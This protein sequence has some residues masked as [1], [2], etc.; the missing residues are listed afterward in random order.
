MLVEKKIIG[1]IPRCYA[2]TPL[3][4]QGGEHLLVASE[5]KERCVLYGLDG[6]EEEVIWTEPGGVMTMLQVPETDGIFLSTQFFYSPNDAEHGKIVVVFP[7]DGRWLTRTLVTLPFVHRFG[8][9]KRNGVR[10]LIACTVKSGQRHKNNDWSF[11][12]KVYAAVL[13]EDLGAFDDEHPLRMDVIMD[14]MVKNHGYYKICEDGA[15]KALI[16]CDSGVYK[17]TPPEKPEGSWNIC[18]ILDT[19]ASD[20]VLVDMDGD[21][22]GEL[23]VISPFHGDTI[24]IYKMREG[25]F[26]KVY[27][28]EKPAPFSHA[29][30]GG[31]LLNTPV[32]IIGH[33]EGA[34][35]LLIFTWNKE[36]AD[37]EARIIDHGC[38]SA[39][40]HKFSWQGEDYILSA[41]REMNEVAVYKVN[42]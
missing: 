3:I 21:G 17:F 4:Y 1:H 2:L 25:R 24:S 8:I 32:V 34:R 36:K 35:D 37:Y 18:R 23:A 5:Q 16:S 40:V 12:G 42:L 14:N 38:G 6:K 13:P 11:P 31:M 33:R 41:N 20:A 22:C 9:L 29:I 15:E 27:E 10:Y 39:N 19:P 28:Y 30:Y 26:V 7:K